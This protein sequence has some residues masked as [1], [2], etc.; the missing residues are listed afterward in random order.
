MLDA[1][2]T[3]CWLLLT[4]AWAYPFANDTK[5]CPVIEHPSSP[6]VAPSCQTLYPSEY[7]IMNSRYP[8]WDLSPMHGRNDMFMLL[9]QR[10]ETFQVAT[11]LQFAHVATEHN[12]TCHLHLQLPDAAL[13]TIAGPQPVFNIYQVE[14]EAGSLAT[15]D[16]YEAKNLTEKEPPVFGQVNG[17]QAARDEQWKTHGGL[18][19]IG[20]TRCNETLTFQMGMA[21]NGGDDVNY[22]DFINVAPPASPIGGFRVVTGC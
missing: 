1:I 2:L 15:W 19:D 18:I 3:I 22:W 21:F 8:H 13:Q 4:S 11:Q 16:M 17:T 12:S 6:V 14:R 9:R 5:P 20:P 10:D 7:R